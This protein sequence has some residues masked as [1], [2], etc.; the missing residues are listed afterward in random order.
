LKRTVYKLALILGIILILTGL[1][2]KISH[3]CG[4]KIILLTGFGFVGIIFTPMYFFGKLKIHNDKLFKILDI[5]VVFSIVNLSMGSMLTILNFQFGHYLYL[6]GLIALAGLIIP[7]LIFIIIRYKDNR[8]KRILALAISLFYILISVWFIK[9][10]NFKPSV[11]KSYG[12]IEKS[13]EEQRLKNI[14]DIRCDYFLLI[15]N[16][17]RKMEI[18]KLKQQSD[19]IDNFIQSLKFQIVSSCSRS[20]TMLDFILFKDKNATKLK[21]LLDSHKD[22]ILSNFDSNIDLKELTISML[23]TNITNTKYSKTWEDEYFNNLP[24][25]GVIQI[26]S[27][28]QL[29]NR[30]IEKKILENLIMNMQ[31]DTMINP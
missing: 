21:N 31:A 25:D 16:H 11:L 28:I 10:I 19:S 7:L 9:V 18:R 30:Y 4:S 24:L 26:L 5:T 23:A 1:L 20:D 8:Y 27:G 3:W 14:E 15:E 29:N 22:F 6:T 17:P 13:L 12:V 2:F